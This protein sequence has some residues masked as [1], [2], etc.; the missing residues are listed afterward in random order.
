[1]KV[2]DQVVLR[3]SAFETLADAGAARAEADRIVD[4]LSGISRVL[5]ESERP[6]GISSVAEVGPDGTRR[7]VFVQLEPAVIRMTAGLV[8]MAITHPDGTVE[9]RRPSD[10]APVWLAKALAEAQAAR[11]LRLRDAAP[12]SWTALYRLFEVIET[13]VGGADVI[14]AKDW[15]S[16][17]QMRRFKHSANSVAAAGDE[18]RHGVERTEPPANPMTISEARALID[19]LLSRWLGDV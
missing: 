3:S 8:S 9:E 13:G 11:A 15:I 12:L 19:I 6:L 16:K 17:S 18:A 10:P 1:V 5:L 2:G 7:N 14:V 4:A